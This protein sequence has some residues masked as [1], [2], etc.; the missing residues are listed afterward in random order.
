MHDSIFIYLLCLQV[1]E[2]ARMAYKLIKHSGNDDKIV[3]IVKR[4]PNARVLAV[5][6]ETSGQDL[7]LRRRG[8][9]GEVRDS[10]YPV[11]SV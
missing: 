9:T 10:L 6:R 2:N 3:F 4:V 5:R 1:V 7:G 8:G 11:G